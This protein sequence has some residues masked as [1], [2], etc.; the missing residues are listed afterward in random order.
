LIGRIPKGED[1]FKAI[2]LGN[3]LRNA[4]APTINRVGSTVTRFLRIAEIAP[5]EPWRRTD[6][7]NGSPRRIRAFID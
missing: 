4:T 3:L 6:K 5:K 7:P 1:G 2:I